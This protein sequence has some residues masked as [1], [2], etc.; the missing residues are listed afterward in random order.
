MTKHV[1]TIGYS[2]VDPEDIRR[3]AV[4]LNAV[5]VDIRMRA[6]SRNKKYNK[7]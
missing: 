4:E 3:L 1:Y 6:G 7:V 2:G 5:V